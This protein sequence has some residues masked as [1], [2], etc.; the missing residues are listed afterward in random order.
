M[1]ALRSALRPAAARNE[2]AGQRIEFGGQRAHLHLQGVAAGAQLELGV[3]QGKG[4]LGRQRRGQR[5]VQR[6]GL[7]TRAGGGNVTDTAREQGQPGF[8]VAAGSVDARHRVEL[9]QPVDQGAQAMHSEAEFVHALETVQVT[10]EQTV[11]GSA[12]LPGAE[13]QDP[14]VAVQ[15]AG[16]GRHEQGHRVVRL[17]LGKVVEQGDL[18]A[19]CVSRLR[20][21]VTQAQARGDGFG[22][23]VQTGGQ[24][25]AA[26]LQAGA[27]F[28]FD[29]WRVERG[30]PVPYQRQVLV[31]QRAQL[32][33]LDRRVGARQTRGLRRQAG[34]AAH[35]V[36]QRVGRWQGVT[37]DVLL[38]VDH[39]LKTEPADD[40]HHNRAQRPQQ[41]AEQQALAQAEAACATGFGV[42]WSVHIQVV[43][44]TVCCQR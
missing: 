29:M 17:C 3:A 32:F 24:G 1:V 28:G 44:A 27:Q 16:E 6:A 8:E 35:R 19:Q 22:H 13:R 36:M 5:L 43:S 9:V 11:A 7:L 14:A 10:V 4:P 42:R 30:E 26:C 2:F 38:T 40:C 23:G 39:A 15:Q 34:V 12:A 41:E 25:V 20:A 18:F 37:D 21:P 33:E 31:H